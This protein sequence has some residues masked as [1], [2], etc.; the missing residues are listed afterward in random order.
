MKTKKLLLGVLVL[1]FSICTISAVS[2]VLA[3]NSPQ[4]Y[5]QD[6]IEEEYELGT[7]LTLSGGTAVD[8]G[9]TY[10]LKTLL[11]YPQGNTTGYSE[12]VLEQIGE[13]TLQYYYEQDGSVKIV[14]IKNFS[15][16]LTPANYFKTTGE[17]SLRA[18][19]DSPSYAYSSGNGV[20]LRF[21]TASDSVMF[22]TPIDLSDNTK[23]DILLE[24]LVTPEVAG[25]AEMTTYNIRFTDSENSNI[26]LNLNFEAAAWGYEEN[27]YMRVSTNTTDGNTFGNAHRYG[28][29]DGKN[30][31]QRSDSSN[32]SRCGVYGYI[33][34]VRSMNTKLYYDAGE[35]ALY[36]L[37]YHEWALGGY[38]TLVIDL[39][40]PEQITENYVWSGFPSG[41]ANMEITTSPQSAAHM[42]FYIVDGKKLSGKDISVDEYEAVIDVHIPEQQLTGVKGAQFPVYTASGRDNLGISYENPDV[43]VYTVGQNDSRRYYPI[44]DGYFQTPE[45]GDYFIEYSFT[46]F[47]GEK[48]TKVVSISVEDEKEPLVYI[49]E[50]DMTEGTYYVDEYIV[51][52]DGDATGYV[53]EY[54][55]EKTVLFKEDGASEF[56]S[57]EYTQ[58]NRG[59]VIL[60]EKAGTCRV[61]YRV[62]DSLKRTQNVEVS[63]E[64][65]YPSGIVIDEPSLPLAIFTGEAFRFP[66]A[67]AWFYQDGIK[68]PAEVKVFADNKEITD[69]MEY[70]PTSAGEAVISYRSGDGTVL[71]K[72]TI[73]VRELNA[74]YYCDNF[75][76]FENLSSGFN[77][78]RNYILSAQQAGDAKTSFVR[79]IIDNNLSVSLNVVSGHQAQAIVI[80]LTDSVRAEEKVVF[81]IK[82]GVSGDSAV[83]ELY[84]NDSQQR[85]GSMAGSIN[86][87]SADPIKIEYQKDSYSIVDFM[88]NKVATIEQY[89]TGN[90]FAGFSS[91][92][93][94]IDVAFIGIDADYQIQFNSISNQTFTSVVVDTVAPLMDFGNVSVYNVVE[95][96]DT[97]PFVVP[98]VGDVYSMQTDLSLKVSF[99]GATGGNSILYEGN[100]ADFTQEIIAEAY[101][102][103]IFEWTAS[104]GRNSN[105]I[106]RVYEVLDDSAPEL[107]LDAV[108][109]SSYQVGET[110]VFPTATVTDGGKYFVIVEQIATG[111]VWSCSSRDGAAKFTFTDAGKYKII[112]VAYDDAMNRNEYEFNIVVG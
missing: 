20:E 64:V 77:Q 45:T 8:G 78:N 65:E 87:A 52:P 103:F 101:G 100:A 43:V 72:K 51:L 11:T 91:G 98:T 1:A 58:D 110:S 86:G 16:V 107:T 25:I 18:N 21:E 112:L 49:P 84:I 70:T 12:A 30:V 63:F 38:K 93:V 79:K 96:G 19:V 29:Q 35:N 75:F 13:Y 28:E 55:V 37:F 31:Y 5:I 33:N 61:V 97:V 36:A 56:E 95:I 62:T 44:N 32:L 40:D 2:S 80:T 3:E 53:G 59:T 54:V 69:T 14:E 26:W 104:D 82:P 109:K 102:T 74:E 66:N 27:L 67:D 90:P 73:S 50:V 41:K 22:S 57:I 24:Y 92:A 60:F 23:N 9:Q 6:T 88:G 94:Y 68:Q 42:L 111:K 81:T 85:V 83:A 105:T 46:D 15:T 106:R 34:G 39:D 76:V 89:A 108:L 48:Q 99:N 17:A 10:E 7:V 47:Y 71:F 4:V